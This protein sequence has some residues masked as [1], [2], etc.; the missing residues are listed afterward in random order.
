LIYKPF[1]KLTDFENIFKE[2]FVP[3][4]NFVN[5]FL[6]DY[7]NSREVVQSS[8]MNIWRNR[9]HIE[10]KT[11]L[12][13]YLYQCVK[14]NMIDF[15]RKNKHLKSKVEL[16]ASDLENMPDE[17]S[18]QLDPFIV[19]NAIENV[20]KNVKPKSREIFELNKFEGLSYEEIAQFLNI[21]KRSV[22]DNISRV[23]KHLK[24]E[25]KNHPYLF[26]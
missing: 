12:K 20:L 3:L 17:D 22:E 19:R 15:I 18:E 10:I 11:S 9:H 23:I 26:N 8:F 4:V 2:Y 14:N 16:D 6:N 21:S 5:T 1:T 7:E 13:A 24:E 25:L